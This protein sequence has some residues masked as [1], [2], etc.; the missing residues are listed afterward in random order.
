[1]HNLL[2][3]PVWSVGPSDESDLPSLD[4]GLYSR[5]RSNDVNVIVAGT[6]TE[7]SLSMSDLVLNTAYTFKITARNKEG[8]SEPY[9]SEDPIVAGRKI[10]K[11][12]Q[13]PITLTLR[14]M[15]T[16]SFSNGHHGSCPM[17]GL[18]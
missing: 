4:H 17:F 7:L 18:L 15:L 10:S 3:H 2:P 1:V 14:Q 12:P 6:V 11:S 13:L 8:E 5:L 9:V 16:L